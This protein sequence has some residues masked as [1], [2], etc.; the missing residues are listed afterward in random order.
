MK[1]FL[2][3]AVSA[4][5]SAAMIL[6][7]QNGLSVLAAENACW[8]TDP[9]INTITTYFDEARNLNDASGHH[10]AIDI[11]GSTGLNIYAVRDGVVT[12]AGW[13]EGYGYLLDI[14]HEDL[15]VYTFYAHLSDFYVSE[16]E[17]VKAGQTVAAMGNTGNSYGSHLHYGICTRMDN[18]WP[19]VTYYDPLTYFDYSGGSSSNEPAND[20]EYFGIYTT[21]GVDTYLN[22]RKSP[23]TN[24]E[25]VGKIEPNTDIKVLSGNG[26]WAYV[27]YNG[28]EGYC[29]MDYIRKT[30]KKIE[31]NMSI[32]DE[33]A[34]AK[35][36][37]PGAVFSVK[38]QINSNLPITKVWGG[39]YNIDGTEEVLTVS[40]EPNKTT[41]DLSEYFDRSL[42][43]ND[44]ETGC[45]TYKI[46]A[47]DTDGVV[48]T[49]I[50]TVF[51]MGTPE[52]PLKGDLNGDN[53]IT[54]ADAVQ[55]QDYLIYGG[56]FTESVFNAADINGDGAVDVFDMIL[57]KKSVVS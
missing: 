51:E 54:V 24:S 34:P 14:W 28:Q 49:L 37:T 15:G 36:L 42:V 46:E 12:F 55:L 29:S 44:L 7:M 48:Y 26:K 13:K 10:N 57:L 50:N 19:R 1:S 23:S 25:V 16:G 47:Q 31:S 38:G 39:I 45:Y 21:E 43:F 8:P 2:K 52:Q 11:S 41:Y 3:K 35:T 18:G 32:S 56:L 30:D 22:I 9:E 6:V 27:E 33:T 40:Q 5:T 20:I 17:T 53:N 4:F